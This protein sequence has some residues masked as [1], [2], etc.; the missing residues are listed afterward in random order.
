MATKR[1]KPQMITVVNANIIDNTEG[2]ITPA[3][4]RSTLLDL[5]E[6]VLFG[7]KTSEQGKTIT[8]TE[9]APVTVTFP[10]AFDEEITPELYLRAYDANGENVGAQITELTN[11][12][13]KIL[14]AADCL[15]DYAAIT[16][17]V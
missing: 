2:L 1:T 8:Y 17:E 14:P 13:F 12:G 16:T 10:E 6:S 7:T 3:I 5:I 9:A 11:S 15:I 4:L